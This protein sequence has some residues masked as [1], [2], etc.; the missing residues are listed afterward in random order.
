[1]PFFKTGGRFSSFKNIHRK[2]TRVFDKRHNK[3]VLLKRHESYLSLD[4]EFKNLQTIAPFANIT[5]HAK[6]ISGDIRIK[7]K[8]LVLPYVDGTD[9]MDIIIKINKTETKLS[10]EQIYKILNPLSQCIDTLNKNNLLHVDIK[11]D[12]CIITGNFFEN[13]DDITVTL[14][15][16]ESLQPTPPR[17]QIFAPIWCR[18]GTKS[19]LAPEMKSDLIHRNTDLWALGIC[20]FMLCCHHHPLVV[21]GVIEQNVAQ[22]ARECLTRMDYERELMDKI[23]GLLDYNPGTRT[24]LFV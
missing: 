2:V 1:M 14:I 8:T 19:Y 24:N 21:H 22:Y 12:N 3:Y 20:A 18:Y 5:E 17:K 23:C 15:D 10:S 6:L 13:K 7:D 4:T 9:L 11:P 16:F